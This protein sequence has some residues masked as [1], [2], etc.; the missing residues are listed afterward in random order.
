MPVHLLG[1]ILGFGLGNV[2]CWMQSVMSY[3]LEPYMNTRYMAHVR[4]ILSTVTTITFIS[5]ILCV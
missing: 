4:T 2:Y 5:S 1:A 3:K